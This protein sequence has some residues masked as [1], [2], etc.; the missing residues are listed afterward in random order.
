MAVILVTAAGA[1]IGS[2]LV[3]ELRDGGETMFL[4]GAPYRLSPVAVS[5]R[6]VEEV[7]EASGLAWTFAPLA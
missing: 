4:L 3:A 6:P 5:H 1:M 7:L 2:A